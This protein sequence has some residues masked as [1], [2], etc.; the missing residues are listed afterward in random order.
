LR[1]LRDLM[2]ITGGLGVLVGGILPFAVLSVGRI[3]T[4]A[5]F[6]FVGISILLTVAQA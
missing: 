4:G 2:I 1:L 3:E 5:L 6:T